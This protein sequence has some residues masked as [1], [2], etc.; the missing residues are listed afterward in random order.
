MHQCGPLSFGVAADAPTAPALISAAAKAVAVKSLDMGWVLLHRAPTESKRKARLRS[1]TVMI[2]NVPAI[3][4]SGARAQD[5][6]P[7]P[8]NEC[9][10]IPDPAPSRVEDARNRA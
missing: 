6:N 2:G 3:C 1:A 9:T 5:A 8:S 7:E 4:H 10:W